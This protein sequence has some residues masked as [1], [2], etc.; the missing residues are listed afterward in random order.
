MI[1]AMIALLSLCLGCSDDGYPVKECRPDQGLVLETDGIPLQGNAQ[2]PVVLTVFGDLKCPYTQNFIIVLN[3]FVE[4]LEADGKGGELKWMFRHFVRPGYPQSSR[5][6]LAL[7]AAHMQ[8]NDAFWKLFWLLF[9]GNDITDEYV[10]LYA[11]VAELHMA[12]FQ[13]DYESDEARAVVASDDSL[14]KEI[15]LSGTPGVV[16]C[17]KKVIPDPDDLIDNLE[18]LIYDSSA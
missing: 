13:I 14:A 5:I 7:A 10:L 16:L 2:A 4:R 1:S 18:Y 12:Q 17:G 6:A 8:G 3:K 15:G 9:A 11:E